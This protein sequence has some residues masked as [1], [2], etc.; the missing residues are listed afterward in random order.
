M[1]TLARATKIEN[2]HTLWPTYPGISGICPIGL[3]DIC[4][5]KQAYICQDVQY[6]IVYDGKQKQLIWGTWLARLVEYV[7]S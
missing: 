7:D 6:S 2:I 4:Q 1:G 5:L 3:T